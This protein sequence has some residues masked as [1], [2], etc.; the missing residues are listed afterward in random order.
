MIKCYFLTISKRYMTSDAVLLYKLISTN[1]EFWPTLKVCDNYKGSQISRQELEPYVSK[2]KTTIIIPKIINDRLQSWTPKWMFE[3]LTISA[4]VI[5]SVH[6]AILDHAN[7][8]LTAIER[9][10]ARGTVHEWYS[11]SLQAP[12]DLFSPRTSSLYW[13]YWLFILYPIQ[14]F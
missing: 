11:Y 5:Q 8:Y 9:I 7:H 3:P 1:F 12:V 13:A 4:V 14:E 10:C 2:K 6:C